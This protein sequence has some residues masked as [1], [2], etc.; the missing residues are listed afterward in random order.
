MQERRAE[1]RM[2]CADL[3]E[4][5][6]QDE[7]HRSRQSTALLEDISRAGACLQTEMPIPTGVS[8]RMLCGAEHLEGTVRYCVYREIGYLVGVQFDAGSEWS[9][10]EFEPEH[11]LDPEKLTQPKVARAGKR[12]N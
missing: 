9:R 7:Q 12:V 11:L 8:L 10:V 5:R 1:M 4:V 6:W 2:L 3:V